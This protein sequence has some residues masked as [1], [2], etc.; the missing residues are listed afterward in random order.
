[1]LTAATASP[2]Y[3]SRILASFLADTDPA[4]RDAR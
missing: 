4:L 3:R 1:L 2:W